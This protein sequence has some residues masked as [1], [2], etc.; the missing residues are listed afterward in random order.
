MQQR[1]S[2]TWWVRMLGLFALIA[3]MLLVVACG[4][5]KSPATA[6][7][8]TA[9][10]GTKQCS[11][12]GDRIDLVGPLKSNPVL[13][14]MSAGFRDEAKKLGFD[15]HIQLTAEADPQQALS[16]GE[17]AL[18]QGTKGIVLLA[19]DPALYPF[20]KKASDA[21]VPVIVTHFPVPKGQALGL[22]QDLLTDPAAYARTAADAIGQ[23]IGGKGTVALTQ[24]SF[25]A[26]ENIVTKTFKEEMTAKYPNVKVLNP[27]EEG[28]DPSK[29]IAKAVAILQSDKSINAAFSSTGGGPQTWSGAADETKR[30]LTIISMDYTRP[31]LDLVK[32]GKVYGLIAQPLYQEHAYAVD[33]IKKILC[34]E[35]VEYQPSDLP[36]PLVTK[37]NLAEFY[38]LVD[39]S[40]T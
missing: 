31:N 35:T 5:S 20:I 39:K 38:A 15:G 40:G 36:A 12:A 6:S 9:S 11:V 16:L 26:T 3:S 17:Q 23:Q 30:K 19:F 22:K 21:G 14:I 24:G 10:T 28:F 29:A 2:P 7:K 34:G 4:D 32:A 27:Q 8:T 37:A 13:Q 18:A 25:N 1:R 33:S